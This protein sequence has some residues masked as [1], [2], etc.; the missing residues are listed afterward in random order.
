MNDQTLAALVGIAVYFL[1][2]LIDALI[3]HGRH[4]KFVDKWTSKDDTDDS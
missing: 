1:M 3:P 4:F 2:R